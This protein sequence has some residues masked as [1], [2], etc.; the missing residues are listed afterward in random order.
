MVYG[1]CKAFDGQV[2]D[3]TGE[4]LEANPACVCPNAMAAMFCSYGHMLEC[5]YPMTCSEAECEH[6]RREQEEFLDGGPDLP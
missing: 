2:G 6:W 5:H 4:P 3:S 1:V